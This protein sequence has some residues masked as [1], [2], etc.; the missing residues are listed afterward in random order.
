MPALNYIETTMEYD[1]NTMKYPEMPRVFQ[2]Q[3]VIELFVSNL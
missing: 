3:R 2:L 1:M